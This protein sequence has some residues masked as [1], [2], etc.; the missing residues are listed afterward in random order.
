MID[1]RNPDGPPEASADR[2]STS[3]HVRRATSGDRDSIAWLVER[4]TAILA[5]GARMRRSRALDRHASDE[6]I[7]QQVWCR[8]LTRMSEFRVAG[9]APGK[10]FL[11]YL[12]V[13]LKHELIEQMRKAIV[14]RRQELRDAASDSSAVDAGLAA[15]PDS[16]TDVV[17]RVMKREENQR[18][19]Q[20]ISSMDPVDQQIICLRSLEQMSFKDVGARLGLKPNTA[21]VR[22]RNALRRLRRRFLGEA[23]ACGATTFD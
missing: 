14:G 16:T 9:T 8:V 3:D 11:G 15:W 13:T 20:A 5:V 18:V 12:S 22:Y 4:F 1:P 7:V 23:D 17:S 21:N 19:L 6:D 10:A 2:S